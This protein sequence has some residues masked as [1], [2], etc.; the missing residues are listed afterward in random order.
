MTW[1]DGFIKEL[2]KL[3]EKLKANELAEDGPTVRK[4]I[5]K[6]K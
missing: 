1:G 2:D 6:F 4:E 5:A 3:L